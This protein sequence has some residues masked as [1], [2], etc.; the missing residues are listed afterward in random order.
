ML[1]WIIFYFLTCFVQPKNRVYN[2]IVLPMVRLFK[3]S[4]HYR[5]GRCG[6]MLNVSLDQANKCL[7]IYLFL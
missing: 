7:A 3:A 5:L 1:I 6:F 2:N 4:I